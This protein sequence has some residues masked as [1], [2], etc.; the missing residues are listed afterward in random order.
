[1]GRK[2]IPLDK[3]YIRQHASEIIQDYLYDED[4]SLCCID[5]YFETKD[6]RSQMKHL[7]WGK[8]SEMTPDQFRYEPYGY[9]DT[10]DDGLKCRSYDEL[11]FPEIVW[12]YKDGRPWDGKT[13]SQIRKEKGE[14]KND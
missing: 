1:M 2:E 8:E 7:F 4:E 6:G 3:K 9:D 5:M 13:L 10:D 11:L 12:H 14:N